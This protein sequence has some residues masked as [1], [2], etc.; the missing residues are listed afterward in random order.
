[1]KNFILMFTDRR[2]FAA[3][4]LFLSLSLMFGTWVIYIPTLTQKLSMSEG[5][6]GFALFFS[7]LGAFFAIPLGKRLVFQFGEGVMSFWS[8]LLYTFFVVMFFVTPTFEI[9]CVLMFFFGMSSGIFQ[10]AVNTVV[11]TIEKE[12]NVS[13]MSTCHGFF[14][15]GGIFA[16]G[17]GTMLLIALGNPLLHALIS[18]SLVLA[19][20]LFSYAKIYRIKQAIEQPTAKSGQSFEA[21]KSPMLWALAAVALCVMVAE[22]AIADWSTLYLRDVA[23]TPVDLVGLGYAGFSLTMALGRFMGD[24]ISKKIGAWQLILWGYAISVV[25]LALVLTAVSLVSLSGFLLIGLG[26][27]AIVPEVYRLS[28]N[29]EGV[30]PSAG[31][32]FMAGAGFF[33]FLAGPVALGAIAEHWGLS[34]S[35][36]MLL[37]LVFAGALVAAF[38]R[39]KSRKSKPEKAVCIEVV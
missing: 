27:S 32:A 10:I 1:M 7:A 30:N 8:I 12:D 2:Y 6:L 37:G 21:L 13:V 16:S 28:S 26:F 29:I 33:G 9:L 17:G 38:V 4:Q 18:A 22:G 35:F 20:Q 15:M 14:S 39:N 36:Y 5:D 23:S 34:F 19:L 31:I 25:G 24:F 3:A 11:S